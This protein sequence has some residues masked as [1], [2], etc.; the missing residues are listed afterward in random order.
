VRGPDVFRINPLEHPRP[1]G[2]R[3]RLASALPSCQR[4]EPRPVWQ[5]QR[6][7]RAPTHDCV[8]WRALAVR[9]N[10]R[11]L[12]PHEGGSAR[13]ARVPAERQPPAER[14]RH[15]A[16]GHGARRASAGE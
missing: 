4:R 15:G 1:G 12:A 9:T 5:P 16:V 14:L 11:E 10:T 2:D 13:D 3:S 8:V 6:P 7:R